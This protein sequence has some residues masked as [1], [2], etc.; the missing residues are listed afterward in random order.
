MAARLLSV[1]L[2]AA[3]RTSSDAIHELLNAPADSQQQ[4]EQT[5]RWRDYKLQELSFVGITAAL[6]AGLFGGAFSCID[7]DCDT[8][9]HISF[10]VLQH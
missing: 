6:I 7:I 8:A 1:I 5:Q 4:S 10:P 3:Y 9:I 2:F